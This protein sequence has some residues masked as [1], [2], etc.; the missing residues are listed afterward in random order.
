MRVISIGISTCRWREN[1]VFMIY[2]FLF[3]SWRNSLLSSDKDCRKRRF[4]KSEFETLR[5]KYWINCLFDYCYTKVFIW[6]IIMDSDLGLSWYLNNKK[7]RPTWFII[8]FEGVNILILWATNKKTFVKI[9]KKLNLFSNHSY[10]LKFLIKFNYFY[11]HLIF[12]KQSLMKNSYF[13][14]I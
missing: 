8:L 9:K 11:S 13:A 2:L 1:R 12:L 14:F 6:S 3:H 4:I 10:F 5:G 7:Q